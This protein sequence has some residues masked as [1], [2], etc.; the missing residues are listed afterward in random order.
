MTNDEKKKILKLRD[1]GFG[2]KAIAAQT[3]INVSTIRKF[4]KTKGKLVDVYKCEYCGLPFSNP[5]NRHK[6][7]CSDSCRVSWWNNHKKES[8]HKKKVPYFCK[9]CGKLFFDYEFKDRK[10]CSRRCSSLAHHSNKNTN[11]NNQ[12]N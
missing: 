6:R 4:L 10:Y 9:E 12:T 5:L 8:M 3:S 2:Y 7:F 1:D 11:G